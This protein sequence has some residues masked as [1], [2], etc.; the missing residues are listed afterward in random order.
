M[1]LY[2]SIPFPGIKTKF[3]KYIRGLCEFVREYGHDFYDFFI[4]IIDGTSDYLEYEILEEF[5]RG[6][7]EYMDRICKRFL[8]KNIK[9]RK[10]NL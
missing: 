1:Y 9:L 5:N 3:D 6:D 10:K 8:R 2:Y 7:M 4:D